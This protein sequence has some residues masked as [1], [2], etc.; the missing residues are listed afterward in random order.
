M[1][2]QG[3]RLEIPAK[4]EYLSLGR[5]AL[6]G[7]AR[8]RPI[9]PE[10]LSDLKVALTEACS[11]STR[12]AYDRHGGVIDIRFEVGSDFIAVEVL[13]R[14]PG[15]GH[16][17]RSGSRGFEEGGLGLALIE[18]LSDSTEIGPREDGAG[19]RVRFV[20]RFERQEAR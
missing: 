9:G 6:A 2:R 12:H 20:R 11:N 19:T 5:L 1:K 16:G 14:G 13:D 17:H 7:I 3:L 18:S 15:F 4:A 10:A 8:A